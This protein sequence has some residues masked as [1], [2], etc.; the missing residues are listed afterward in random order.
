[1]RP[2]AA[3]SEILAAEGVTDAVLDGRGLEFQSPRAPEAT[4]IAQAVSIPPADWS[5]EE[6]ER[7]ERRAS[8]IVDGEPRPQGSAVEAMMNRARE[9]GEVEEPRAYAPPVTYAPLERPRFPEPD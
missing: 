3:V 6:H 4:T 8:T 9:L 5:A 1:M 7:A 2:N